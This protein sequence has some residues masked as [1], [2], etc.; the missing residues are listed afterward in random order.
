M[1][2]TSSSSATDRRAARWPQPVP[3]AVSTF[4]SSATTSRGRRRMASGSTI[5]RAWRGWA[6]STRCHPGRGA[7]RLR[8]SAARARPAVR[9]D[10]QRVASRRAAVRCRADRRA[11]GV[12]PHRGHAPFGGAERGAR[13]RCRLIVRATG[14]SGGPGD[15]AARGPA[16]QTAFGVV[17]ADPP[18]GEL[19]R[20]TLMDFRPPA[21]D[22]ETGPAPPTFVYAL[23]VADGWLVEETV[24]AARPAFGAD[25]LLR[26]L[27]ARLGVRPMTCSPT[28]SGRR[29]SGSRW[30]GRCPIATTASCGSARRRATSI[31]RPA[32]HSAPRCGP[33]R[34]WPT[35]SSGPSPSGA[36]SLSTGAWSGTRCGPPT[37]AAPGCSTSTG[38]NA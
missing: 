30:A 22:D 10:R 4:C 1:P 32:S 6:P 29:R 25:Q 21:G 27:A 9:G 8:R 19:G 23:P 34:V 12:D 14:T 24:L 36:A 35:R 37:P 18:S 7:L 5:S 33:R 17:L 15:G 28:P 3:D 31:R 20:P 16:W 38:W 13:I 11:G 2:P 26:R